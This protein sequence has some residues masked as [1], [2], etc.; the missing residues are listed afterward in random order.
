ML[1]YAIPRVPPAQA[2]CSRR[3]IELIGA[4]GVKFVFNTARRL[5]RSR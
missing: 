4:L 5:R 2:R 3:E 1:R